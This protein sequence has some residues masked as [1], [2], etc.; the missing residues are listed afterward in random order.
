LWD[1]LIDLYEAATLDNEDG[2]TPA[3][4][5]FIGS[6]VTMPSRTGPEEVTKY[7]LIDGQQR[8]TTLLVLL[9]AIRDQAMKAGDQNLADKIR[10]MYLINAYQS[11]TDRF[12]IL[13]TVGD[14]PNKSDRAAFICIMQ[15]ART[16]AEMEPWVT[17]IKDLYIYFL[18]KLRR[19]TGIDLEVLVQTVLTK[20]LLVSIMVDEHDN[21]HVI[22]ES[23]NY[24]G[25][26]LS[27]S[28]LIRN[29]FFMRVHESEHARVYSAYWQPM[30]KL[31]EDAMT[32]FIRHFMMRDGGHVK[33]TDVYYALKVKYENEPEQ[34]LLDLLAELRRY[35]AFYACL[36]HQENESS[37]EIRCRLSRLNRL[38]STVLYPFL[39][40]I[41]SDYTDGAVDESQF[42]RILDALENFLIRRYVCGVMR[43]PLNKE[44]P[45]L[46]RRATA[47][48]G[49]NL[50]KGVQLVLASSDY[51]SDDEFETNLCEISLYGRG[52]KRDKSKL[53]LERL[54][55]SFGHKE[56]VPLEELTVEHVMP[57]TLTEWWEDHLGED[58]DETHEELLHTLGNLTLTRYN[59]EL[60]NADYAAKRRILMRSHIELNNHFRDV[61]RWDA[62]AISHRSRSLAARAL[63]I[64]PDFRPKDGKLRPLTQTVKGKR[65]TRLVICGEE[66]RV[67][68]W[69][70]VLTQTLEF[71]ADLGDEEFARVHAA[72][73][74]TIGSTPARFRSPRRLENGFF[75]ESHYNAEQVYKKCKQIFGL[76]G[77]VS[78]DWHV[79][80]KQAQDEAEAPEASGPSGRFHADV[81]SRLGQERQEFTNLDRIST[82]A[83][84]S[85]DRSVCLLCLTSKL[86][87]HVE[88]DGYWFG[89]RVHQVERLRLAR[90][91]FLALGCGS[92]DL[93]FVFPLSELTPWLR[94]L[95][96]TNT[97]EDEVSYWHIKIRVS[98]E[99]SRLLTVS[100]EDDIDVGAFRL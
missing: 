18:N 80:L 90:H 45:L 63:M 16:R 46:Y 13:P 96:T 7:T 15:D 28:D 73:P 20:L 59:P 92:A 74:K 75:Y 48:S 24:K 49:R 10:D 87:A 41:Y 31:L 6:V 82:T 100:G 4:Q 61:E 22:F 99:G 38:E 12:K 14:E 30:E 56:Q 34:S 53:I 42:V 85:R 60:S 27:Q 9:A 68:S 40:N 11:D 52:D 57:Q 54:E 33:Q 78:A 91:S 81:I 79:H 47:A 67:K 55:L 58:Y 69:Q 98:P 89:L 17:G 95:H 21:P 29:Y 70:D 72:F 76:V 77:S 26:P 43:A 51:P 23:L 36:I 1:D 88:E 32:E 25:R 62:E 65:P 19:E 66:V 84:E 97:D 44:M 71:I 50:V 3:K 39:L 94:V 64:W 35:A 86:H 37:L 5:H 93:V 8:L 83:Y 2:R